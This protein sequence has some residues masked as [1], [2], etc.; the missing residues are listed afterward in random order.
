MTFMATFKYLNLTYHNKKK[1]IYKPQKF[2]NPISYEIKVFKV[3][4]YCY[5]Y[6]REQGGFFVICLKMW[7]KNLWKVITLKQIKPLFCSLG[8]LQIT[9]EPL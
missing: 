1:T 3:C 8:I 7:V 2:P 6:F 4:C 5:C 9:V